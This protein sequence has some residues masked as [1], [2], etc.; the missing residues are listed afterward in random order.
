MTKNVFLSLLLVLVAMCAASCHKK[1]IEERAIEDATTYTRRF[2]PTPY[3]GDQR[4]D[5]VTFT[6]A[7][8]TLNYYYTLKGSADNAEA[9]PLVKDKVH[10]ALVKEIEDNT[11]WKPY[12]E[13]GFAFSFTFRSASS[14]EV[15][16]SETITN[17]H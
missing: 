10:K 8:R 1:S 4:T 7:T 17:M 13:A 3:Q 5:S 16:Y 14:G 9:I 12:R 11:S 2:C 15:L 6:K